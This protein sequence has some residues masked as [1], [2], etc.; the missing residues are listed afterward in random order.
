MVCVENKTYGTNLIALAQSRGLPIYPTD[1]DT[2]KLTRSLTI[3][4]KY[5]GG[6]V[7]HRSNAA[8]LEE[9]EHELLEFPGGAHDDFV[10]TASDAGIQSVELMCGLIDSITVGGDSREG[11]SV[12]ELITDIW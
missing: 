12:G 7:F 5:K 2:D 4:S 8:W 10:D 11:D 1:S 6:L 3:L 9:I